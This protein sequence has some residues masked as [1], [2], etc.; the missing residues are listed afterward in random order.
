M[1]TPCSGDGHR[2]GTAPSERSPK[3]SFGGVGRAGD[4]EGRRG[5]LGQVVAL[6][7]AGLGLLVPAVT[8]IVAFLN[9][10]GQRSQTGR[11]LRVTSLDV[12]PE[13]GTPRRFPAIAD[14][15]DAWNYFPSE[16]VGAVFLRRTGDPNSPVEA[17]Q[18]VCPHMGCFIEYRETPEGGIFFCP[19]HG[20]SFD[21]SGKRLELPS[22]SPRDMDRLEIDQQRLGRGEVWVRFQN[23]RTG[24][25]EPVERA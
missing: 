7:F 9:P 15:T 23:F 20:A 11:L 1:K 5:F 12:L 4:V 8:G 3:R 6:V 24:T 18:V 10:L 17:L 14:R 21:L 19:C 13:D 22:E 25:S 2:P 16:P